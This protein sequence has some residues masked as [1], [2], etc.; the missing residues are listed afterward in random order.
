MQNLKLTATD[1]DWDCTYH[2]KPEC[3]YYFRNL[4]TYCSCYVQLHCTNN[5][6][7]MNEHKQLH[8]GSELSSNNDPI[9]EAIKT[10]IHFVFDRGCSCHE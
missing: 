4:H 1:K 5:G 6:V 10:K 9:R 7:A 2:R 8:V 3:G